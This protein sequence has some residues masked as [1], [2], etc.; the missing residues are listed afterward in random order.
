MNLP[1]THDDIRRDIY[2][3]GNIC[4]FNG[5]VSRFYSVAEH[6]AIGLECMAQKNVPEILQRA[7]ALHDLPEAYLGLGDVARNRKRDHR[8]EA[9]VK[10]REGLYWSTLV[11]ILDGACDPR[12]HE[13]GVKHWDRHMAVAEVEAVALV[14]HD[15]PNDY[16]PAIHGYACARIRG[17]FDAQMGKPNLLA[18]FIRLFPA[19]SA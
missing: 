10:P 11:R 3:L 15:D 19:L 17:A 12:A 1:V 4:R 9:I 18:H 16:N 14:P 5:H 7:F 13:T 8:V 6:T 2:A